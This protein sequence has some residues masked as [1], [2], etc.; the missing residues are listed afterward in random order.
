MSIIV[1][2]GMWL[3]RFVIIVTSLN[4]NF[5]PSSWQ[6]YAPTGWDWAMYIGTLGFFCVLFFLFI[7]LLPMISA[8]EMRHVLHAEHLGHG[9]HGD[10]GA[11][12][13]DGVQPGGLG[14]VAH[15]READR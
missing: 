1:N 13:P 3:E 2:I 12:G 5:L 10:R 6:P 8:F 14:R 11:H 4:R 15:A 7:R 9:D